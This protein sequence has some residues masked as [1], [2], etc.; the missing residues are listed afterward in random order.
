MS[1]LAELRQRAESILAEVEKAI[2]GKREPL[3]H[4]D[5]VLAGRIADRDAH[6]ETVEL[7]LG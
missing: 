4:L 1:A 5:L 6:E 3:E 7:R 2:V